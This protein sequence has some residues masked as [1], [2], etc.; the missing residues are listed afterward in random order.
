LQGAILDQLNRQQ[1]GGAAALQNVYGAQAGAA[2]YA[3]GNQATGANLAAQLGL[4]TP[5][6]GTGSP[7]LFQGSGLLSLTAQNQMAGYNQQ[8]AANQMN[9]QSG[10][11]AK[12]AMI[13]AAGAIGG[14]LITGVA[15]F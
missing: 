12:G 6:Y 14:A 13:G 11:A 3:L 10:G 8:A 5:S 9:A 1:Q 2:N 4:S 7:N 15:L